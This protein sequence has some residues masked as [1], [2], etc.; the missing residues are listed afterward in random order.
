M[1]Q[2]PGDDDTAAWTRRTLPA[3]PST[4]RQ[5]TAQHSVAGTCPV[6]GLRRQAMCAYA[7]AGDASQCVGPI[8]S[9]PSALKHTEYIQHK[10][11]DQGLGP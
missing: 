2:L 11:S 5:S 8:T 9:T 10:V 4:A 7:L 6:Q 3:D 1:L